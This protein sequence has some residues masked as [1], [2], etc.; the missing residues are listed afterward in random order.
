[1]AADNSRIFML[2]CTASAAEKWSQTAF[3]DKFVATV[4]AGRLCLSGDPDNGKIAATT[5]ADGDPKQIWT[6]KSTG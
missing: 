3:N 6:V 5:C 4:K 1:V 2:T